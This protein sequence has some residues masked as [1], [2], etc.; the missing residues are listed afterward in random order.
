MAIGMKNGS[1][2]IWKSTKNDLQSFDCVH[3]LDLPQNGMIS[4]LQWHET[5]GD[6]SSIVLVVSKNRLLHV[7]E[8][9]I[10]R[11]SKEQLVSFLF[12]EH[13]SSSKWMNNKTARFFPKMAINGMEIVRIGDC[14]VILTTSCDGAVTGW[15]LPECSP[16][17]SQSDIDNLDVHQ[18]ADSKLSTVIK[19]SGGLHHK[20]MVDICGKIRSE[21]TM[22]IAEVS[23]ASNLPLKRMSSLGIAVDPNGLLL[24]MV[25]PDPKRLN[26]PKCAE[27]QRLYFYPVSVDHDAVYDLVHS[28]HDD[29]RAV[30]HPMS[31]VMAMDYFRPFHRNMAKRFMDYFEHSFGRWFQSEDDGDGEDDDVEMNGDLNCKEGIELNGDSNDEESFELT[32]DAVMEHEHSLR[33]CLLMLRYFVS[34]VRPHDGMEHN[35]TLI[36]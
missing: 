32:V 31:I 5:K 28:L 15:T 36:H 20:L 30:L 8:I 25:H 23:S 34:R 1:L 26:E 29:D 2:E 22:E 19:R 9:G 3:R 24:V 13:H 33:F 11:Q 17:L 7:L 10:R 27:Q 6:E 16:I 12:F 21:L 4:G 35:E 18:S 14:S